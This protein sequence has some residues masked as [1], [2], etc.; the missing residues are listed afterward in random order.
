[1]I[2]LDDFSEE[3]DDGGRRIKLASPL[4]FSHGEFAEEIFVDPAKGVVIERRGNLRD[5][6]QQFL[7]ERAGEKVVGLGKDACELRV[8]LLDVTHS[9]IND[10]AHV[11]GF[12]QCQQMVEAGVGSEVKHSVS[13]VRAG[14]VQARA[15]PG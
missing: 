9:V 15:A 1:M 10:F 2:R 8:V 6:F 3:T 11:G 12:G 7:E 13:V 14:V 4:P 5:L